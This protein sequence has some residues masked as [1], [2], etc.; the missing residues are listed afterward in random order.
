MS[1]LPIALATLLA[2]GCTAADTDN[3]EVALTGQG[4]PPAAWRRSPIARLR[5]AS[6][7]TT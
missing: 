4:G 1:R 3:L 6:S 2:A 7:S 5:S